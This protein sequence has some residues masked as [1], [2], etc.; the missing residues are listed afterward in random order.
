MI[1]NSIKYIGAGTI[2][3]LLWG[4]GVGFVYRLNFK[5][6][7]CEKMFDEAFFYPLH[8]LF[9]LTFVT[10]PFVYA[11]RAISEVSYI[12]DKYIR[13]NYEKELKE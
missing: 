4:C 2:H 7:Y 8:Y 3:G 12:Y 11:P 13:K 5:R 10:M 1:E 6:S 9:F